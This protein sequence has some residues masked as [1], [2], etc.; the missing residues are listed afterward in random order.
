MP[1]KVR[2]FSFLP[3]KP[4]ILVWKN[5]FKHRRTKHILSIPYYYLKRI[6]FLN[7]FFVK[8]YKFPYSIG[9]RKI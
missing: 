6:I 7:N 1:K 2:Y 5:S 8:N 9:S 4:E 3:T